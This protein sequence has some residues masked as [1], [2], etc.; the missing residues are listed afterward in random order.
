ML[1]LGRLTMLIS[2]FLADDLWALW[3][4]GGETGQ[5]LQRV[6]WSSISAPT[7]YLQSHKAGIFTNKSQRFVLSTDVGSV[8]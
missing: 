7:L 1:M 2:N 6:G 3:V 5:N 8:A 4:Y